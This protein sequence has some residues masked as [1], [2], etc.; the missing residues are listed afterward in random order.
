MFLKPTTAVSMLR[1][2]MTNLIKFGLQEKTDELLG[3]R[4]SSHHNH[5]KI[6]L[7][8]YTVSLKKN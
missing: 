4:S 7:L 3:L 6:E 8:K 5:V 2:S 1:V